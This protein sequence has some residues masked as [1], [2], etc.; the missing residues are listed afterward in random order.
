MK[1]MLGLF[2]ASIL[3]VGVLV[4]PINYAVADDDDDDDDIDDIEEF[5]DGVVLFYSSTT[6]KNIHEKIKNL[7][8]KFIHDLKELRGDFR[9]GL[10]ELIEQYRE[11]HDREAFKE[12]F[13]L[14]K[15]E[16]KIKF[17]EIK[18]EYRDAYKEIRNYIKIEVPKDDSK[19]NEKIYKEN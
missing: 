17:Y 12:G 4:A 11:D 8:M 6:G 18:Q 5:D 13:Y 2:V 10:W 7:K 16:T 9:A 15:K 19:E 14:L 3:L 1:E